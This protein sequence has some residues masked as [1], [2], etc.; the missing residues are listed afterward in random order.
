M[1]REEM[2]N[3]MVNAI[4]KMKE[5]TNKGVIKDHTINSVINWKTGKETGQGAVLTCGTKFEYTEEVLDHWKEQL[6]A[7]E[8]RIKVSGTRLYITFIAYYE[9]DKREADRKKLIRAIN[10]ELAKDGLHIP[11]K[12]D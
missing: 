1:N 8:F 12:E 10:G 7:D 5:E 4:K 6:G 2:I 11:T 9:E 3:K